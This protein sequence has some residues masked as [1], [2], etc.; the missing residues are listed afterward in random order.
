MRMF[1]YSCEAFEAILENIWCMLHL[2]ETPLS[3]FG[4]KTVKIRKKDCS[5]TDT[6]IDQQTRDAA[7]F[8]GASH[9]KEN[10][11]LKEGGCM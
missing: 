11:R 1:L 5:F 3:L 6:K 8:K 4:V 9:K 10:R 2:T 7:E